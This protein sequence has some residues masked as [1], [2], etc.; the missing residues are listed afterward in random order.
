MAEYRWRVKA[1]HTGS[2]AEDR[3]SKMPAKHQLEAQ[4]AQSHAAGKTE[5]RLTDKRIGFR[6]KTTNYK[7]TR[8]E[9]NKTRHKGNKR[10]VKS[11]AR[12]CI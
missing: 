4:I 5:R 11:H 1:P 7:G 10:A 8:V 3:S 12:P 2:V 9:N 6:I